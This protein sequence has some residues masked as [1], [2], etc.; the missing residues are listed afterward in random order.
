MGP[1]RSG[2]ISSMVQPE[3][4]VRKNRTLTFTKQES[5]DIV[6]KTG[7]FQT[8]AA[9]V[10]ADN[11]PIVSVNK[12]II[13]PIRILGSCGLRDDPQDERI[14]WALFYYDMSEDV[15]TDVSEDEGLERAIWFKQQ[16]WRS[17]GTDAGP[18][19]TFDDV[20]AFLSERSDQFFDGQSPFETALGL[21]FKSDTT[22]TVGTTLRIT[23]NVLMKQRERKDSMTEWTNWTWEETLGWAS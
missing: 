19:E 22:S 4:Q 20:D 11:E 23:Y 3:G 17:I 21:W 1:S 16:N 13:D 18:T 15:P 7:G 5:R 2:I 8:V 6:S 9:W 14:S 10:L 12:D